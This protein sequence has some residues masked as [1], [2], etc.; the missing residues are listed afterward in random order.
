MSAFGEIDR[1]AE[2]AGPDV[3]MITNAF[4]AHLE[5]LGSVEGVARPRGSSSCA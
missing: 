4:P 3:G 1:L 5:T 2:I